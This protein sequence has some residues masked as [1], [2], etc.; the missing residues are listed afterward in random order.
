M[1]SQSAR[2]ELKSTGFKLQVQHGSAVNICQSQI[3]FPITERGL[4][5]HRKDR[6]PADRAVSMKS[7]TNVRFRML[8]RVLFRVLLASPGCCLQSKMLS[9]IV[10]MLSSC[11]TGTDLF[12]WGKKSVKGAKGRPENFMSKIPPLL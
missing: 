4:T 8:L 10:N 7:S 2:Q 3:H 5:F 12:Y 6:Y 11:C 9:A 1:E